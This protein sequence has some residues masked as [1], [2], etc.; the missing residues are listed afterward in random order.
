MITGILCPVS[1]KDAKG[2]FGPVGS[3]VVEVGWIALT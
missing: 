3:P 2:S 1:D